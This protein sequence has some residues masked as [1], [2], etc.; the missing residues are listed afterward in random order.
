MRDLIAAFFGARGQGK[1][2][3]AAHFIA[4]R[5]PRRLLILDPMDE[6]GA[7]A[8]RADGLVQLG[9]LS[10]GDAWRLRYVPPIATGTKE[11]RAQLAARFAAFCALAMDRGD[12]VLVIEELQLFTAPSWAPA[13]WSQCTLRGRHRGLSIVGLS[14]RPASV[15]K[16]FLS[17]ANLVSTCRLNWR[18][19]VDCLAGLLDVGREEIR[20]LR[21]HQFIAR[22][23][24]TGRVTRHHTDELISA[25][26]AAKKRGAL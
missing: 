20:E 17:N 16:N 15:D 10:R 22:N 8:R 21:R 24:D 9:A 2:T 23:M 11:E 6:Y 19:D 3:Q 26:K 13:S 18:D 7:W 25:I 4:T 14:Q 1:S 12:L 5:A